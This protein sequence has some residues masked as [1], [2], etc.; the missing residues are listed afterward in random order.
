[1]VCGAFFRRSL[2][3]LHPIE[4][5][6]PRGGGGG[7]GALKGWVHKVLKQFFTLG[8]SKIEVFESV[9]YDNV[10]TRYVVHFLGRIYI[11]FTLLGY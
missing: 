9:F 3:F 1:M 6:G 4:V 8:N 2:R 10:T 11:F 5:L 7:A